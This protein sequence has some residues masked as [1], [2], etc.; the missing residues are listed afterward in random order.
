MKDIIRAANEGNPEAQNYLGTY[1]A[2]ERASGVPNNKLGLKWYLKAASSGYAD[3]LW[4][5]GSM[6]VDG[7]DGIEKDTALGLFLIRIAADAFQTSACL[8]LS[9]CYELGRFG[10]PVE[11]ELAQFWSRMAYLP[12]RFK[13]CSQSIELAIISH[14]PTVKK[15]ID[16]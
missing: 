7:E 10:L 13:N 9:R 12:E 8:Y 1:Y 5:A 15:Y 14:H 16:L 4:N 3:A 6:L 2:T 11:I